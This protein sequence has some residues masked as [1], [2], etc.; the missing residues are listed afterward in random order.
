MI[1]LRAPLGAAD[2]GRPSWFANSGIVATA[3]AQ[4]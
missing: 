4:Q 1:V 2:S 3:I